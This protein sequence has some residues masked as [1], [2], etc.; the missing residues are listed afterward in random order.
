[1]F[2]VEVFFVTLILSTLFALGG[3]GSAT[4]LVPVTLYG[5]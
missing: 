5:A 3:V 1:M 2:Y 4:A